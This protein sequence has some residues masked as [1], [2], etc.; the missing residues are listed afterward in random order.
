[1]GN[2][3]WTSGDVPNL[4]IFFGNNDPGQKTFNDLVPKFQRRL[5]YWKQ[6]SLTKIGKARVVEM[7]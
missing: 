6:F 5:A 1:M 4:E 3:K 7:F 2:I